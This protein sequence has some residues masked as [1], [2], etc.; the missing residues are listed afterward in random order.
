MIIVNHALENPKLFKLFI[1]FPHNTCPSQII[2]RIDFVEDFVLIIQFCLMLI[3][4]KNCCIWFFQR[5][6][7]VVNLTVE[8]IA[9]RYQ[10]IVLRRIVIDY[11][12]YYYHDSG[13]VVE[14]TSKL[15]GQALLFVVIKNHLRHIG[16]ENLNV[17]SR[18]CHRQILRSYL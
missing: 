18:K 12:Q 16:G 8:N 17:A 7:I 1:V 4:I 13:Q 9:L 11:F 2:V 14:T 15:F 5:L 3:F 6:N 10:L